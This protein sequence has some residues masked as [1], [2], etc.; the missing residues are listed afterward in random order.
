MPARVATTGLLVLGLVLAGCVEADRDPPAPDDL[1][2]PADATDEDAPPPDE[3]PAAD[4]DPAA[5]EPAPEQRRAAALPTPRTEVTGT[6]WE[7]LIVAAGGLDANG[8]AVA[9]VDLYDP[10]TD[11]WT[12]GPDLPVALHHTAVDALG[13][14]VYAVGGYTIEGGAWVPQAAVWSL[15]PGEDAWRAEPPLATA[16]GALAVASTGER[17]VAVGGVGADRQVLASTEVLAVGADAWAEGPALATAREHLDATAVR[18]VVYAIAGRAGGLDTN[19]A[20]VEVLRNGQWEPAPD[21]RHARGGIGAD[22]VDGLPCVAGGEEPG[23]TIAPIECF[24]EGGWE[25][26]GELEVPRHGL[27]VAAVDDALHVIGGGPD[28]GLTVS[29]VHEIVPVLVP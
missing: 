18:D 19:H 3:D 15:G 13:D 12:A 17:L 24:V 29:D 21:V 7:G 1:D 4:D 27:V 6:A 5:D 25:V 26:I 10:A 9:D 20:S 2:D 28:P 16:R 8:A 11:T 23:T 22:T 14:R